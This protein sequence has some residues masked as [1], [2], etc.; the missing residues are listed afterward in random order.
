MAQACATL[1]RAWR[2]GACEHREAGEHSGGPQVIVYVH[3]ISPSRQVDDRGPSEKDGQNPREAGEHSGGPQTSGLPGDPPLFSFIC[4]GFFVIYRYTVSAHD[5]PSFLVSKDFVRRGP[6]SARHCYR[7][8]GGVPSASDS[9]CY[10]R[11]G[12]V[13]PPTRVETS[14]SPM[15]VGHC[16]IQTGPDVISSP[17]LGA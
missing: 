11:S 16:F 5:P 9:R 15:V 6:P 10:R 7:R 4:R 3:L 1:P 14:K 2:L 12:G 13:P 17:E 8:S